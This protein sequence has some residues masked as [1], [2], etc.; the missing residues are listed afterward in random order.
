MKNIISFII[1][2]VAVLNICSAKDI[3]LQPLDYR[4]SDLKLDYLIKSTVPLEKNIL[5]KEFTLQKGDTLIIVVESKNGA[6]AKFSRKI[7]KRLKR[8]K[9]SG[10]DI[11]YKI[12]KFRTKIIIIAKAKS[13]R[14]KMNDL[15]DAS[16]FHL[17]IKKAKPGEEIK[18]NISKYGNDPQFMVLSIPITDY[19][20]HLQM[21]QQLLKQSEDYLICTIKGN[22]KSN[23]YLEEGDLLEIKFPIEKFNIIENKINTRKGAK[24]KIKTEDGKIIISF[25]ERKHLNSLYIPIYGSYIDTVEAEYSTSIDILTKGWSYNVSKN[26]DI[27]LSIGS[28]KY[29]IIIP[30]IAVEGRSMTSV[31]YISFTNGEHK[32]LKKGD[33][34]SFNI[35]KEYRNILKFIEFDKII[36]SHGKLEKSK[37]FKID[38]TLMKDLKPGKRMNVYALHILSSQSSDIIS[39]ISESIQLELPSLQDSPKITLLNAIM[40]A[41]KQSSSYQY[42]NQI[43]FEPEREAQVMILNEVEMTDKKNIQIS[44]KSDRFE[45]NKEILTPFLSNSVNNLDLKI[46]GYEIGDSFKLLT[47]EKHNGEIDNV[48]LH[49]IELT[50]VNIKWDR[51][52]MRLLNIVDG[53]HKIHFNIIDT[54]NS[55]KTGDKIIISLPKSRSLIF[56]DKTKHEI[57]NPKQLELTIKNKHLYSGTE[58]YVTGAINTN[59][60]V[61]IDFSIETKSWQKKVTKEMNV[62]HPIITIGESQSIIKNRIINPLPDVHIKAN[63][64]LMNSD[65]IQIILVSNNNQHIAISESVDFEYP[66]ND[67]SRFVIPYLTDSIYNISA[68]EISD[69]S[70]HSLNL[71]INLLSEFNTIVASKESALIAVDPN[72]SILNPSGKNYWFGNDTAPDLVRVLIGENENKVK[73]FEESFYLSINIPKNAGCKW[74][75]NLQRYSV[76]NE[77]RTLEIKLDPQEYPKLT[78]PGEIY[79]IGLFPIISSKEYPIHSFPFQYKI[80]GMDAVTD[81][82]KYQYYHPDL[83]V[84][85]VQGV[86]NIKG[87]FGDIYVPIDNNYQVNMDEII[88]SSNAVFPLFSYG[89]TCEISFDTEGYD[90]DELGLIPDG[91]TVIE[92]SDRFIFTISSPVMNELHFKDIIVQYNGRKQN[93][94]TITNIMLSL[95]KAKPDN[96]VHRFYFDQ[97][98]HHSELIV[99]ITPNELIW[100][101][102]EHKLPEITLM[103]PAINTENKIIINVNSNQD[104]DSLLVWLPEYPDL[105]T[106]GKNITNYQTLENELSLSVTK[107]GGVSSVIIPPLALLNIKSP[108]GNISINISIDG[109]KNYID[110]V[111]GIKS[112]A[113]NEIY[114]KS[115]RKILAV[116]KFQYI[117][118]VVIK[119]NEGFSSISEGDRLHL[120]FRS[121]NAKII[122]LNSE[123]LKTYYNQLPFIR[124][125]HSKQID[126]KTIQ[127]S[128]TFSRALRTSEVIEIDSLQIMPAEIGVNSKISIDYA[129][130]KLNDKMP[131]TRRVI[132]L[133]D[134]LI[135][136]GT[137][138]ITEVEKIIY[139]LSKEEN[140]YVLP[141]LIIYDEN[142][143]PFIQQGD[144]LKITINDPKR[145]IKFKEPD[146]QFSNNKLFTVNYDPHIIVLKFRKNIMDSLIIPLTV[147]RPEDNNP[148]TL[149]HI[150]GE[151]IL[152]TGEIIKFNWPVEIAFSNGVPSYQLSENKDFIINAG[153]Q[154]FPD[155]IFLEDSLQAN[156][157]RGDYL[158]LVLPY[159]FNAKWDRTIH[160]IGSLDILEKT[161][162]YSSG[163]DTARFKIKKISQL[164][165]E[166]KIT[167][168]KL[169]HIIG[170][171]SNGYSPM[172]IILENGEHNPPLKIMESTGQ[173]RTG[174][175]NIILGPGQYI[176]ADN[177]KL[178][179]LEIEFEQI[180]HPERYFDEIWL[181]LEKR[182]NEKQHVGKWKTGNRYSHEWYDLNYN[183]SALKEQQRLLILKIKNDLDVLEGSFRIEGLQFEQPKKT[184]GKSFKYGLNILYKSNPDSILSKSNETLIVQYDK[185]S[186]KFCPELLSIVLGIDGLKPVNGKYV[187]DIIGIQIGQENNM[188]P[189]EAVNIVNDG[190]ENKIY[191]EKKDGIFAPKN[192]VTLKIRTKVNHQTQTLYPYL[193]ADCEE[194]GINKHFTSKGIENPFNNP[195]PVNRKHTKKKSKNFESVELK[196]NFHNDNGY[197]EFDIYFNPRAPQC[198]DNMKKYQFVKL[199][200]ETVFDDSSSRQ[201]YKNLDYWNKEINLITAKNNN[202]TEPPYA[203]KSRE[204]FYLKALNHYT[205]RKE[206]TLNRACD[207]YEKAI[208]DSQSNNEFK[209]LPKC[210]PKG[211]MQIAAKFV[212]IMDENKRII[213]KYYEDK[214]IFFSDKFID[215][216]EDA[217]ELLMELE[218][219]DGWLRK[220]KKHENF[221]KRNV[222]MAMLLNDIRLLEKSYIYKLGHEKFGEMRP[223][224]M[225]KAISV[226]RHGKEWRNTRIKKYRLLVESNEDTTKTLQMYKPKRRE[227]LKTDVI[228]IKFEKESEIPF[229]ILP[230]VFNL[231]DKTNLHEKHISDFDNVVDF[232]KRG[233]YK[234]DVDFEKE[235]KKSHRV[236]FI[237]TTLL[238][239]LLLI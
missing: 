137:K 179:N 64:F 215:D 110:P 187:L 75:E 96:V 92:N 4:I 196:R 170:D 219:I 202:C 90:W 57:I 205:N 13:V 10:I 66:G 33:R 235:K 134:T 18:I 46:K 142:N 88:I 41:D 141:K 76:E 178:D 106:R 104:E 36:F 118:K 1:T 148:V 206:S 167:G 222:D 80:T 99:T 37:E 82:N 98:I 150:K 233:I 86:T 154:D 68:V 165:Q 113:L 97:K 208:G 115:L 102:D 122:G 177:Q 224:P 91:I 169:D 157:K 133:E 163:N 125:V 131:H 47:I 61:G 129:I 192:I 20:M 87:Q 158:S 188:E 236:A 38:L 23:G 162:L 155:I 79:E 62:G 95:K 69:A 72:I 210:M 32:L 164:N 225:P 127:Y 7:K 175:V 21:K 14:I 220:F 216:L 185:K 114:I 67:I 143:N 204:I 226:K 120:I 83:K 94:Y 200:L 105:L 217:Q 22:R 84:E 199:E 156:M 9:K 161:V 111:I 50:D 17:L 31:A 121:D 180:S 152:R 227:T 27:E 52:N 2:I 8:L 93:I 195:S 39:N 160:S 81:Y 211:V 56:S 136:Y 184:S 42:Y 172:K 193:Q 234:I 197:L 89:D 101:R 146:F 147:F 130:R 144:I 16:I 15:L 228:K 45:Y 24:Y 173:I 73:L 186:E 30:A 153:Q 135:V 168:L 71:N 191:F 119:G 25:D 103:G 53:P 6:K 74:E 124:K 77:G 60:V 239:L 12:K 116:R 132:P 100:T 174:R 128:F 140:Q 43:S 108:Q 78:Q 213:N 190:Y 231:A 145:R 123:K 40:K 214:N 209:E 126:S 201:D 230:E 5:L 35:K 107:T 54:F 49:E 232:H 26:K 55:L 212:N 70:I 48:S 139:N 151:F 194:G 238:L 203:S 58:F 19:S 63:G 44:H 221:H 218:S 28:V 183:Y 112:A 229:I 65:S 51:T 109:G 171:I 166:F 223:K 117:G 59:G 207:Y 11:K 34:I 149:S 182:D 159:D 85:S 198:V 3:S 176:T 181:K 189:E 237:S 138:L 29:E